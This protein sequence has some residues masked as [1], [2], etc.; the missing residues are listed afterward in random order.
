MEDGMKKKEFYSLPELAKLMGISRIA[1]FKKVKSGYIK[2]KK[3]GKSYAVSGVDAR[4]F[5]AHEEPAKYGDMAIFREDKGKI[6]I[7]TRLY[8]DTVWLSLNQMAGLFGRDK[9]VVSRHIENV[10]KEG[11]LTRES[12]VA[13]FA[14]TAAD[15]KKYSVDHY[16]LDVIISV[17][18]RVK[19][20]AGVKFRVWSSGILKEYLIKGYAINESRLKNESMKLKKL[21]AIVAALGEAVKLPGSRSME[22]ELI[23]LISGYSGSLDILQD[24][25]DMAL[26]SSGK[27]RPVYELTY[28]EALNVVEKARKEYKKGSVLFGA[29]PLSKL[30][31]IIGAINQ[32]FDGRELYPT[33]EEKAAHLL[34]FTV[35][36]HPFTDGNKRLAAILFLHYMS[37]NSLLYTKTGEKR[38]SDGALAALTL[39]CAVSNPKEKDTMIN[40]I[41]N[42]IK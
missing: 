12:V 23:N 8:K 2:A 14:T 15:G 9:S 13:N 38:V 17:G 19:S 11:E 5:I 18:Y 32:T 29:G 24:Y 7:Q 35:K 36:D 22:S 31:S 26:K 28:E 1:V 21:K 6:E 25:D 20:Q 34:Y 40:V 30:K 16:N 39:L 27:S 33:A 10:F 42:A 41:T 37:K 4:E 3:V